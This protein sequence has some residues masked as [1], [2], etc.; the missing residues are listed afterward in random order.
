MCYHE[1]MNWFALLLILESA[2]VAG[3]DNAPREAGVYMLRGDAEWVELEPAPVA[4]ARTRGL[5]MF[6][7][8]GGYTRFFVDIAFAGEKAAWRTTD[9]SPR[10]FFR[11][12]FSP[13]DLLIVRLTP[14][15]GRRLGRTS[16]GSASVTNKAGFPHAD[17][18]RLRTSV[19][20]D[21]SFLAIPEDPLSPGEYLLVAGD[22]DSGRDF[23]V[24]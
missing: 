22:V 17:L 12:P 14:R 16:P 2:L 4:G 5:E 19:R 10:F 21:G 20:D 1:G 11:G 8:T 13:A 15:G 6:I 3:I 9:R 23:G 18:V 24:D 7:E